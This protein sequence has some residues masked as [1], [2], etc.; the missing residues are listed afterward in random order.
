MLIYN[1]ETY[2][3]KPS[4]KGSLILKKMIY[5]QKRDQVNFIGVKLCAGVF[6]NGKGNL[7]YSLLLITPKKDLDIQMC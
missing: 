1:L 5:I 3:D 4:Y 6:H 2:T 7:E